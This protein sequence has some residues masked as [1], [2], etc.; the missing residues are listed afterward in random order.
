MAPLPLL[1]RT[2][3]IIG[4]LS[5]I[6]GETTNDGRHQ[7]GKTDLVFEVGLCSW[8]SAGTA[9]PTTSR[10]PQRRLGWRRLVLDDLEN[11]KGPLSPTMSDTW[12]RL[13]ADEATTLVTDR[14]L[15]LGGAHVPAGEYTLFTQ[16]M[17]DEFHLIVNSDTG[18]RGT[19][20]NADSDVLHIPMAVTD[21]DPPAERLILSYS[22]THVISD[23][24][25]PPLGDSPTDSER[26]SVAD[27]T[28]NAGTY[29]RNGSTDRDCFR[30]EVS[31]PDAS[32]TS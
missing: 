2:A 18:Q 30:G 21:L 14:D 4:F 26:A 13:G 22:R 10:L 24:P 9:C 15:M 16:Q 11:W 1:A 28:S 27:L 8:V 23:Q 6:S 5:H 7:I 20:Y 19:D 31:G 29:E 25:R 12:W 32:W 3:L 17:N